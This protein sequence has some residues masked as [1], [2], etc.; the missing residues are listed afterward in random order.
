M[1]SRLYFAAYQAPIRI[2]MNAPQEIG[3]SIFARM[4]EGGHQAIVRTCHGNGA[5]RIVSAAL[6]GSDV[7]YRLGNAMTARYIAIVIDPKPARGPADV[8]D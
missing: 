3:D 2:V 6:D 1:E 4:G 5:A 7:R 8:S